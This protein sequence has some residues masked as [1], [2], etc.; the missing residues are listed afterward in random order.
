MNG[1]Y[2]SGVMNEIEEFCI[3]QKHTG[4]EC[5]IREDNFINGLASNSELE[6]FLHCSTTKD[7]NYYT[8][9]SPDSEVFQNE[10]LLYSRCDTIESCSS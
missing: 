6:C 8:W 5:V 7:C 2:L 4:S 3:C 9:Y 1:P 10:C